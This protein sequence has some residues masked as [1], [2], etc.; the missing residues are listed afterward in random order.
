MSSLCQKYSPCLPSCSEESKSPQGS[1]VFRAPDRPL[2]LIFL[3]PSSK[4]SSHASLRLDLDTSR[5]TSVRRPYS[6]SLCLVHLGWFRN[7]GASGAKSETGLQCG[8]QG[9]THVRGSHPR[10]A[11]FL[12]RRGTHQACLRHPTRAALCIHRPES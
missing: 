3:P 4:P 12:I 6:F 9:E 11:G 8:G 1:E 5:S 7:S 2:T 10:L